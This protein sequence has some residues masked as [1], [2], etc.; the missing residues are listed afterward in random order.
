[1]A[2]F[3]TCHS[4]GSVN[5]R[6]KES[7]AAHRS[8]A[9]CTNTR[10]NLHT[11]NVSGSLNAVRRRTLEFGRKIRIQARFS[12]SPPPLHRSRTALTAAENASFSRREVFDDVEKKK[13]LGKLESKNFAYTC[14]R[15][16]FR[17][18]IEV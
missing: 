8:A 10:F 9:T 4:E 5:G 11:Y 16:S 7:T 6:R 2:P 18:T 15:I 13:E 12:L 14:T 17:E 3:L 1:M